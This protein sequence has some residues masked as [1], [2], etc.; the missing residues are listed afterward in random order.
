MLTADDIHAAASHDG[1]E[2]PGVIY[3]FEPWPGCLKF[4]YTHDLV[5][6]LCTFQHD[7]S[8]ET[9]VLRTSLVVQ[10]SQVEDLVLAALTPWR[11]ADT[12]FLSLPVIEYYGALAVF[13]HYAEEFAA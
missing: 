2:L 5:S 9:Q 3:L 12:E 11:I 4:G 1:A 8:L 10:P 6:R 7:Y 13:D